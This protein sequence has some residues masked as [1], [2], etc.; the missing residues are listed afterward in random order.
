[1]E[2]LSD[3]A[4]AMLRNHLGR[5]WVL[6]F[7]L[8]STAGFDDGCDCG[9]G[10]PPVIAAPCGV[11]CLNGRTC[12]LQTRE[13]VLGN[14]S[15]DTAIESAPPPSTKSGS[16]SFRFTSNSP[17]AMFECRLDGSA[18]AACTSPFVATVAP[19]THTFEVRAVQPGRVDASPASV[20]WTVTGS[21]PETFITSAPEDSGR[22]LAEIAFSSDVPTARFMCAFDGEPA[23]ECFEAAQRG[24]LQPGAHFFSVYAVGENG[25]AD[26]TPATHAWQV[27]A[28]TPTLCGPVYFY[29]QS[30]ALVPDYNDCLAQAAEALAATPA[31]HLV[32]QGHR[33]PREFAN[34]SLDRAEVVKSFLVSSLAVEAARVTTVDLGQS[35]LHPTEIPSYYPRV[36]LFLREA[37][38]NDGEIVEACFP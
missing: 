3:T 34:L 21:A 12:D 6:S 19:G 27:L 1:M 2:H 5:L 26:P 15:L 29:Y 25:V 24:L 4:A 13:C 33:D 22:T 37:G 38:S 18:F 32:L 16:A 8:L 31:S 17:V 11:P 9:S 20:I 28:P 35:C 14:V 30:G 23:Y 36:T 7:G 10:S